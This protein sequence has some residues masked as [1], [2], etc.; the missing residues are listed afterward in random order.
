MLLDLYDL[1]CLTEEEKKGIKDWVE[2]I[3]GPNAK[4]STDEAFN[5]V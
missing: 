2:K 4:F 3:R 5:H 1:D